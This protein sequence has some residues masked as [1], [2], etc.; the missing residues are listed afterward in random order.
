MP[1]PALE[2]ADIF[3]QHGPAYRQAHALPVYQHQLMRAIATCRTAALGGHVETCSQCEHRRISYNSCRN[4]HCPKC[5][6][7][8]RSEWLQQRKAELLPIE[9]FHVVFTL[10]KQ[11]AA[12]AYQNKTAV[13][14][15]LFRSAAETLLSI[16]RDPKHLGAEIG[17]F[18]ILHTWGQNLHHHPHVHCVVSGGGL[19]PDS[20]RFVRCRPGFFLPVRVLSRLFRRLFLEAL[21]KAFQQGKLR[22]FCDLKHLAKAESFRSY[23]QPLRDAE[24]VVYAKPPFAGPETVLAYLARYTHRVAIGNARLQSIENGQVTFQA[25]DYRHGGHKNLTVAAPEFIRRFLLHALPPGFQRIRHYGFLANAHRRDKLALCRQ[26]LTADP[27]GLLPV[28]PQAVSVPAPG[29]DPSP[30]RCPVCRIGVMISI[31]LLPP[32]RSFDSS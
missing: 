32:L 20:D 27:T 7:K 21:E 2:L 30:Y 3:R 26:L 5:Q 4:R 25:K 8:Q 14:D 13:Y 17:F 29:P 1:R 12:L 31:E 15:I 24:W 28:I 22:F 6:G 10:P 9:Y 18:A 19:P 11:L 16:A 23:L